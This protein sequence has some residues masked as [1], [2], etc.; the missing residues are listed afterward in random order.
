MGG[1]NRLDPG[2]DLLRDGGRGQLNETLDLLS[3][4]VRRLSARLVAAEGQT[5]TDSATGSGS[6]VETEFK[7]CRLNRAAAQSTTSGSAATISWDTEVF[8]TGDFWLSGDPTRILIPQTGYYEAVTGVQ[9]AANATGYRLVQINHR[10]SS[11]ASQQAIQTRLMAVTG[12]STTSI[13]ANTGAI[14]CSAGDYLDVTI[15]QTSGGAL[16]IVAGNSNFFTLR[17][18]GAEA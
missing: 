1:L 6:A 17:Y 10:D 8:D 12:G 16:T 11:G 4:E 18:L 15:F 3:A 7:G 13:G 5:G 2:A 9:W 14:F